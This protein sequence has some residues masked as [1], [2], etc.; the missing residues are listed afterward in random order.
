MTQADS[1]RAIGA[2][3]NLI[4][5]HLL[6]SGFHVVVGRAQAAA[7]GNSGPKLNL[8]LYETRIDASLRNVAL[9]PDAPTPLWLV[10]KYMLTA[11]DATDL[12][13]SADAH[14]LLGR[15]M[16]AL[17]ELSYMGLD[18]PLPAS[19]RSALEHNPE[20]LKITFDESPAELI[21]KIMQGEDE[22]Y[23]LSAAFEVRPVM[24]LG[25]EPPAMAPLVGVDSSAPD[26][27][28][29]GAGLGLTVLPSLGPR[30]AR[31]APETFEPGDEIA[32]AGDELHLSGIECWVGGVRLTVVARRA[33][34]LTVLVEGEIEPPALE[35]PIEGGTAIS[36]GEHPISVRQPVGNQR[37]RSSNI[38]IGRLRPIVTTAAVAPDGTLSIA[39]TLLGTWTDDVV[40]ALRRDGAIARVFEPAPKPP[41]P[42]AAR[43][44]VPG[45]GQH[46]LTVSGLTD[47]GLP[48]DPQVASGAYEVVVRVNGQQARVNPTVTV[49]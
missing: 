49:A 14:E 39:G 10:L 3:T 1:G 37:M 25:A 23:R 19:V 29:A 30:L 35:G 12:S 8:F 26:P 40:V 28:I 9:Q 21:S 33:D 43:T 31:L 17:Q 27:I 47:A 41:P 13:D 20:P 46:A 24:I 7:S 4:G 48:G 38:L 16:A 6:S 5:Q 34:R 32:L 44:V 42:T 36:A 2:V 22:S 11:F 15:G 18:G 45:A